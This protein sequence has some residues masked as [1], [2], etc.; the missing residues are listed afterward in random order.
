MVFNSTMA[1]VPCILFYLAEIWYPIRRIPGFPFIGSSSV[2]DGGEEEPLR[3]Q[4]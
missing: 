1:L 3:V 2:E 4:R